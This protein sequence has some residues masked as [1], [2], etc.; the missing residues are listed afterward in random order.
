MLI[1]RVTLKNLLSF[2][3]ATLEL[4]PLNVLIGPKASG[5]TNFI[6]AISLLRAAP[7][8]LQSAIING[9]GVHYWKWQEHAQGCSE[10]LLECDI[11]KP[12][13]KR[14]ELDGEGQP[15]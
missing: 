12:L 15:L 8:S 9:G 6:H 2:R 5:K 10:A 3:D 1:S 13:Q 7:V 11:R 14:R 4:Q